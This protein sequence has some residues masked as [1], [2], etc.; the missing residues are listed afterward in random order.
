MSAYCDD[1]WRTPRGPLP[2]RSRRRWGGR[3]LYIRQS[4]NGCHRGPASPLAPLL[5]PP[6]GGKVAH[7]DEDDSSPTAKRTP[8]DLDVTSAAGQRSCMFDRPPYHQF[9]ST[10]SRIEKQK[11]QQ[12]MTSPIS[13]STDIALATG[14]M[15][16]TQRRCCCISR[17]TSPS[18]LTF[19][20]ISVTLHQNCP[21]FWN[22]YETMH[23]RGI[24]VILIYYALLA[25]RN[26]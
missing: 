25:A 19:V 15:L 11:H 26:R 9:V 17:L 1:R 20:I 24:Y 6:P 14:L 3:R 2:A 8:V 13:H 10:T 16:P 12:A 18:S 21:R 7:T 23:S 5:L 4:T 22:T